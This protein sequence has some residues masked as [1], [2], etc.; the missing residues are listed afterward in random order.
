MNADFSENTYYGY[1]VKGNLLEAIDYVKQFPEQAKR[2]HRFQ[3]VFEKEQYRTYEADAWVHGV[4]LIYQKY[5]RDVFYLCIDKETAANK[6]QARLVDFLGMDDAGLELC[7]LEQ[8]Q[9][10]EAFQR[11][12]FH[13]LGGRTSGYYGPYIWQTTETRVYEVELPEGTQPYMVRLLDSFLSKSWIDYISFG[14]IGSGGWTDKEGVINC[15]KSSYDFQSEAFTVSLLKHEAQH[16]RDLS[17]CKEMP[18]E[19]L[20]YRAKLVELIYST[21]RNLLA[22]FARE[23]DPSDRDNGHAAAACRILDGFARKLHL[24]PEELEKLPREKVQAVADTLFTESCAFR[25]D[26]AA[27]PES[28]E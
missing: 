13:F 27:A 24:S 7:D 2:Y 22:Q 25:Q 6:L 15:V 14:E 4:L 9:L 12:G 28:Q 17:I 21:E 16:A 18:S 23:A 19:E 1:L 26:M 8:N 20:E 10:T 11:K 3:E 5:Y